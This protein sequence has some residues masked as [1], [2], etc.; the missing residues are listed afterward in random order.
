MSG[1]TG[2]ETH[3]LISAGEFAD[4]IVG[5]E[6]DKTNAYTGFATVDSVGTNKVSVIID[7]DTTSSG[8]FRRILASYEPKEGDRVLVLHDVVIG[9]LK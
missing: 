5:D 1:S 7:G 4:L 9:K 3:Y 6:K 8:K 2:T